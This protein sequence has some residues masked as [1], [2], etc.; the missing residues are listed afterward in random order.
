MRD[1]TELMQKALELKGKGLTTGEIADEF[2]VSRETALWLITR[3]AEKREEAP[4][5][6]IHIDWS[7]IGSNPAVLK[8]LSLALGELIEETLKENDLPQP[9][10]IAGI[11]TSG[12]PLAALIA[13]KMNASLTVIRPNKH[14]WEPGEGKETEQT[15]FIL[16][17]FADVKGKNIVIVDD[18]ATSGTTLKET[19][20]LLSDLGA[21][22]VA[23]AVMI[24]KK[25][26][27]SIG[28]TPVK[29]LVSV[30]IVGE[31]K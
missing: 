27:K 2:N 18:I 29:A 9:D 28:S 13:E 20:K 12:I 17:N 8:H 25:G 24:D 23:A 3:E 21:N 26:I 1:I 30:S 15:G 16:S 31:L 14:L 10:V 4:P 7:N 5:K 22:P 6:D 11:A 19:V